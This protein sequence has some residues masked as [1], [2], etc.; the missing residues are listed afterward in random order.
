MKL[1]CIVVDD[2]AIQRM[3]ITK[4]VNESRII[5]LSR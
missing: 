4:L 5:N 3:I 1:N 2:S